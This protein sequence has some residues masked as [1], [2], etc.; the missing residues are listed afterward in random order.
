MK[1][2]KDCDFVKTQPVQDNRG[3]F[4]TLYFCEHQEC[5]D[6]VSGEIMPCGV[7]RKDAS[8]CGFNA[9]YY[10]KKEEPVAAPVIQLVSES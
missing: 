5:A 3:Q 8:F 4:V 1:L 6:P 7:V 2:C 9:K 10:K